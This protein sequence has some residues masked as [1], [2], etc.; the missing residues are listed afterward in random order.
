L[1]DSCLHNSWC[2]VG[3]T[4]CHCLH[5]YNG[6]CCHRVWVKRLLDVDTCD[7]LARCISFL[8][9]VAFWQVKHATTPHSRHS[10]RLQS[11]SPWSLLDLGRRN[12]PGA[13]SSSIDVEI[14]H[15]PCGSC[16]CHLLDADDYPTQWLQVAVSC[17][18]P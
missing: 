12:D 13:S 1:K 4:E 17:S 6:W 3:M 5:P 10:Q 7:Q 11:R 9:F 14:S 16:R 15:D 2:L 8:L 18:H